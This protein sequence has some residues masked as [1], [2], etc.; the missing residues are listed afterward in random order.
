[1]RHDSELKLRMKQEAAMRRDKLKSL[2]LKAQIARLS[3]QPT[4]HLPIFDRVT[5]TPTTPSGELAKTP[6]SRSRTPPN[7]SSNSAKIKRSPKVKTDPGPNQINEDS[8]VS[9]EEVC[10]L[11]EYLTLARLVIEH[12]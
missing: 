1:M 6:P 7:P 5:D 12:W 4:Q 2:E 8:A 11:V 3:H 9:P 10:H